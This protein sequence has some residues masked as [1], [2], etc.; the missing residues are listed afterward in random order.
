MQS[1]T[2][3]P[4]AGVVVLNWHGKEKTAACLRA[5]SAL[6]Y[7]DRVVVVIDNGCADF[8]QAAVE[9]L[10][11]GAVYVR[12]VENLGFAGGSNLGAK[13]A[14]AR[15]CELLWF[16]NNDTVPEPDSLRELV[17]VIG[18]ERIG[19]AGAKVLRAA[20][21]REIDSVC[22]DVNVASG[23]TCLRGHGEIDRGQ[24]D[25]LSDVTAVTGCAMLVRRATWEELGGFDE[26]YFA[27]FEDADLCLRA[28]AAGWRVVAAPRARV[29][30]DRAAATDGRQSEASLYYSTRN[31]LR[32][33]RRHG[34]ARP[35]WRAALRFA[36][37]ALLNAA[38]ALRSAP[39]RRAARLRAVWRGVRDARPG[40]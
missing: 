23:R 30:H 7:S 11:P 37:V 8:D 6:D 36:L 27:Y 4:R 29:L 13:E 10:L 17:A 38:F 26:S 40:P 31:Q 24:H 1:P 5:L 15:G 12:A 18:G 9:A 2:S 35:R 33:M 16:L 19:I 28:R 21:P 34:A 32:L 22:M 14:L 20:D 25:G 39:R 3:C